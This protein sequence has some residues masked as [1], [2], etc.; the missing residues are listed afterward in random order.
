M[1]LLWAGRSLTTALVLRYSRRNSRRRV[2]HSEAGSPTLKE[3]SP[4]LTEGSPTLKKGSPTL[5]KGSPT[6]KE[7]S[8]QGSR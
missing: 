2:P 4:T 6:L 5:K 7:G 1:V 3:G 8:T